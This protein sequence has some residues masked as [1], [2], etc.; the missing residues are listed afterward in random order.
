MQ[1]ATFAHAG[2]LTSTRAAAHH[3][4]GAE[5]RDPGLLRDLR[6]SPSD[7]GVRADRR[8]DKAHI[9]VQMGGAPAGGGDVP[10]R[11]DAQPHRARIRRR[12]RPAACCAALDELAESCDAGT[13][14]IVIGHVNDVL[15]YRELIRRGVSD[16]L[17]APL[18]ASTS[19]AAS[20]SSITPPAAEPVGPHHR[21][22]RLKGG[23]GASTIAHNLAWAISRGLS[24]AT[25]IADS[26]SALAR[27]G[28]N[29]NQDPPQG[30][31]EAVF[32]PDRL[33]A[34]FLDR[35]LSKC[36]ETLHLLA[37]P[38]TLDRLYDFPETSFDVSH[39]AAAGID[40]L[41][42]PRRAACVDRLVPPRS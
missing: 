4:A 23:V 37:A 12:R 36:A 21:G 35:L 24:T 17:I 33:D 10:H 11:A 18:D 29:F 16:Y 28:S 27:R 14:V 20:R 2:T 8:M 7:R 42:R 30:I 13:K 41:H 25:V 1:S 40:A 19:S 38:A 34:N 3:R 9:K 31:A 6:E 22:D 26:T 32:A 5:D 15:L 39:R